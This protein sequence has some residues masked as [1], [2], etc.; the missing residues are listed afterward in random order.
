MSVT[1]NGSVMLQLDERPG[2]AGAYNTHL[3]VAQEYGKGCTVLEYAARAM[4]GGIMQ[5]HHFNHLLLQTL[6]ASGFK[7]ISS[8]SLHPRVKGGRQNTARLLIDVRLF[9]DHR[10]YCTSVDPRL[11]GPEVITRHTDKSDPGSNL[12]ELR[13]YIT[14][15]IS[16]ALSLMVLEQ[17]H[18]RRA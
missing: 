11:T 4:Q 7:R 10:F 12:R 2:L 8:V 16:T 1:L 13:E 6:K 5:A 3:K 9:E 18:A 15:A 14:L 17:V